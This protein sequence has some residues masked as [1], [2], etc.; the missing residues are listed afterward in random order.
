MAGPRTAN[1][2][3]RL[4]DA[5]RQWHDGELPPA[6]GKWSEGYIVLR[7]TWCEPI[8]HERL[9]E[10]NRRLAEVHRLRREQVSS[11]AQVTA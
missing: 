4:A 6:L 1:V 10:I 7:G 11:K 8:G 5:A 9:N 2:V 3:I